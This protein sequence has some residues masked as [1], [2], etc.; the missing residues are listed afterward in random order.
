MIQRNLS[1]NR[2]I[3][4]KKKVHLQEVTLNQSQNKYMLFILILQAICNDMWITN[5]NGLICNNKG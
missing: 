2:S 3:Q 1:G 4:S 5:R